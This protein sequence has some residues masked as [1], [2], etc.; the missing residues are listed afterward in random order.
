MAEIVA[1]F[2]TTP[3]KSIRRRMTE[4]DR[5]EFIDWMFDHM[6]LFDLTASRWKLAQSISTKYKEE[7]ELMTN[8]LWINMLL[9]YGICKRSDGTYDFEEKADFTVD[10]ACKNPS[11]CKTK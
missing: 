7:T 1:R 6:D 8:V 4:K 2:S 10:D 11:L 9:K 3:G 5:H